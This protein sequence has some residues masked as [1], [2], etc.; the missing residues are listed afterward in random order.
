MFF[1]AEPAQKMACSK[2]SDQQ[3]WAGGEPVSRT[4]AFE[5]AP[6]LSWNLWRRLKGRLR[7]RSE[8]RARSITTGAV[9]VVDPPVTRCT[10]APEAACARSAVGRRPSTGDAASKL[11]LIE[12]SPNRRKESRQLARE[13]CIT[14]GGLRKRHELLTDEVVERVRNAEAAPDGPRGGIARSAPSRTA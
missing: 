14:R 12:H 7:A 11:V 1:T 6:P 2:P 9:S 3:A 10:G 4:V 8:S 5:S 13:G